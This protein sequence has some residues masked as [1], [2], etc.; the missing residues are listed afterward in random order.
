[1]CLVEVALSEILNVHPVRI[2]CLPFLEDT[3]WVP[4]LEKRPV[5]TVTI[6]VVHVL[7]RTDCVG[8]GLLTDVVNMVLQYVLLKGENLFVLGHSRLVLV[9]LW[10]V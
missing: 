4:F 9:I 2:N 8:E 5:V 6:F 7:W 1:M 10:P 3:T